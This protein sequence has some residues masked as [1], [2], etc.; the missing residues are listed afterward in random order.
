MNRRRLAATAALGAVAVLFAALLVVPTLFGASQFLFGGSGAGGGGC[1]DTSAA[2][3]QPAAATDARAIPA[4]YL[5]LYK[6]AGK[7]Y[8]IPWNVLAGIGK[9]ET[10]HGMSREPGVT[11]GEN[12]AG[13]GGPMQFLKPTFDSFAVDGDKDGKKDRYDPA[14]AIPTAAKYLKHNGAPERMRTA[15]FMYNHSSDYVDLVLDWAKKYASGNFEAVQSDGVNCDD[16][17]LPPEAS[18]LVQKILAFAL[19]QR[20][21]RYV[22]GATGPDAWDCSSLIQAAYAAVGLALPRTTFEQ[23]PFGVKVKKGEEQP[24]DLVFFNSGP[25]T[26]PNNPGHVG[27]VI[28]KGKM[29][30][31]S[32]SACNPA[33]GV[34]SYRRPDWVGTTRPLARKDFKQKITQLAAGG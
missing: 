6:A 14:D 1:T 9:V 32:C 4:A 28:G 23:W 8:G 33:I 25:G 13:A 11:S 20:G 10:D 26:S 30:V 22:F 21:K 15:I 17:D 12:Y 27:M 31:A 7:E 2:G 19:A 18:A 5:E 29:V 34:K 16:D 3:A 24:G